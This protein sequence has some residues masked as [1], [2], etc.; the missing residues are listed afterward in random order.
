MAIDYDNMVISDYLTVNDIKKV[1]V[2]LHALWYTIPDCRCQARE[3]QDN[4][5]PTHY[6]HRIPESTYNNTD[7]ESYTCTK[8]L[9]ES[10]L[11]ICKC[12]IHNVIRVILLTWNVQWRP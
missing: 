1:T 9:E 4:E 7:I 3:R 2:R 12:Y 8:V 11:Y 6:L 5:N 10:A